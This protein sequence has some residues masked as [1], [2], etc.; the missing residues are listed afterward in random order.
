MFF[1]TIFYLCFCFTEKPRHYKKKSTIKTKRIPVNSENLK[2][3]VACVI[4]EN[5]SLKG[6][7]KRYGINVMT[8]KRYVR[9]KK[10]NL[11]D[12][13]ISYTSDYTK[14]KVFNDKEEDLL[15][16]YLIKASKLHQE[17]T[18]KQIRQLAFKFSTTINKKVPQSWTKNEAAGRDWLHG[19]MRRNTGLK[20]CSHQDQ[21]SCRRTNRKRY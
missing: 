7:A 8:L 16:E 5:A 18:G 6:T 10:A 13:D 11:T 21:V 3:A 14:R 4:N 1:N 17:L 12:S 15:K 19:F 20:L 9:T 2:K